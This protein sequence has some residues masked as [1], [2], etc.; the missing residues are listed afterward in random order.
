MTELASH[1]L[2]STPKRK[3]KNT[4]SHKKQLFSLKKILNTLTVLLQNDL[5]YAFIS[6]RDLA[7]CFK[8]T[9]N[10]LDEA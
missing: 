3:K 10:I 4:Q 9:H 8:F 1:N 7:L 6:S 5:V 2:I